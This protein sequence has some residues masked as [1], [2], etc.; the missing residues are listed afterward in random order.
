[1]SQETLNRLIV[2]IQERRLVA[3]CGA[4]LSMAKPSSVPSAQIL[5]EQVVH[6]YQDRALPALPA[7][8]T[9]NL[10]T[11][12]EYFWAHGLE[13]LFVDELVKWRPFRRSPN[14]G[15][16]TIADLL[17]SEA[18]QFCVTTNY[19]ELVE[20]SATDLG[21]DSF[22]ASY[23]LDSAAKP[24]SHRAYVKLHGCVRDREHTLWCRSQL[25][26]GPPITPGDQELRRRITSLKAWLAANLP[27]K[28]LLF[29]GFWS[30]WSYLNGLLED[31]VKSIHV[32]LVVLVDPGSEA[33][34]KAK[35][36][37]L[38]DW[39]ATSTK[40][41]H[42][43]EKGEVF[44]E[45]LRGAFSRNL[46]TQVLLKAVPGFQLIKAGAPTPTTTFEG[47]LIEDLHALRRDAYGVPASRIARF[48]RPEESMDAV[49]R[50][51][52]LLRHSGA[53]LEGQHYVTSAG[54]KIRVVNGKTRL[55]SRTKAYFAEGPPSP[56][57]LDDDY[58]LCAG[59]TGGEEVHSDVV[60]G[61][62]NPGVVRA[63]T[64]ARWITLETAMNDGL[65]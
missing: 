49:G 39:A 42:I 27:Q 58:V 62:E 21:E 31:S 8:A 23:D 48:A 12:T 59:G 3:F 15:H 41:E 9:S 30:D 6:E 55:V 28:D 46:L 25:E 43:P 64:K 19:D 11:L 20:L 22:D 4:G 50:A 34:L 57:G 1:M 13:Q 52:L 54:K 32:P 26:S 60:R 38:W 10:E 61:T 14:D 56:G 7:E 65:C 53:T 33:I 45:Q 37:G 40:F 51:H 16:R 63:G 47:V 35:A 29:V 44:L 17:T 2:S 5:T 24:R 36:P 18:L